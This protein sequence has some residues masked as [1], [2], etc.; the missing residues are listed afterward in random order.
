MIIPLFD[1]LF[2]SCQVCSVYIIAPFIG[3]KIEAQRGQLPI[4]TKLKFEGSVVKQNMF[5][6]SPNKT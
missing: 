6:Y 5:F 1:Q 2:Q 4:M 3:E